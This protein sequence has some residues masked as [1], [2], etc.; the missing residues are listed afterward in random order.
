[1]SFR[2][3]D[4]EVQQKKNPVEGMEADMLKLYVLLSVVIMMLLPGNYCFAQSQEYAEAKTYLLKVFNDTYINPQNNAKIRNRLNVDHCNMTF[5]STIDG[6]VSEHQSCSMKYLNHNRIEGGKGMINIWTINEERRV[7]V[8]S[9]GKKYWAM[10]LNYDGTKYSDDKIISSLKKV[11]SKCSKKEGVKESE[12]KEATPP[13]LSGI[14]KR[15]A[16]ADIYNQNLTTKGLAH[17]VRSAGDGHS[18]L[19]INKIKMSEDLING[20]MGDRP[21]LAKLRKLG[22]KKIE[23]CEPSFQGGSNCQSFSLK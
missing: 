3:C 1:M 21:F 2:L 19:I 10:T 5:T 16:F 23:F 22:F 18:T 4:D 6:S 13:T 14:Q 17:S 9:L 15:E 11:I 12:N 7:T 20:I 8:S